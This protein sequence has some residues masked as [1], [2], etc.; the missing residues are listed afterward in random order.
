MHIIYKYTYI[1]N[2]I[3]YKIYCTIIRYYNIFNLKDILHCC[4]IIII[5]S[6]EI[7]EIIY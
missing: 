7:L 5:R 4:L 2:F 6:L 3:L 1:Y